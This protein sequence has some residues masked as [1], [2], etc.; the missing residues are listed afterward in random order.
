MEEK[1]EC[2]G[3]CGGTASLFYRFTNINNGRPQGSCYARASE[4]VWYYAKITFILAF[5]LAALCLVS[6]LNGMIFVF[7]RRAYVQPHKPLEFQ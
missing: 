5:T 2:A 7:G 6:F 4:R 1:L 3:W